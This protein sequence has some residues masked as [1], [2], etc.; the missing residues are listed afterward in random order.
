M[1]D[2]EQG[3]WLA[4]YLSATEISSLE[5]VHVPIA[6]ERELGLVSLLLAWRAHV[7]RIEGELDLSEFERA[8]WGAYDLLAAL[9]FR[10]F[11]VLGLQVVD[12]EYRV[13]FGNALAAV[14]SKFEEFTELDESGIVRNLDEDGQPSG[15]WWWDRIPRVGPIRQ[16]I[17][18]IRI[19]QQRSL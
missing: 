15:G 18:R 14:D 13:A 11:I 16:E 1:S 19:S 5:C 2:S 17:D 7:L 4:S 10:D 12:S 6:Q 3:R 8:A 9:A